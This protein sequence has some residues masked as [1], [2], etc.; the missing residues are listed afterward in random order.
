MLL[1]SLL[2]L[3]LL[4][5]ARAVT[6][7]GQIPFGQTSGLATS[8][9]TAGGANPTPDPSTKLLAA[10]DETILNPPAPPQ[11]Q[12]LN[13]TLN[14][15]SN[16]ASVPNLSIM[17]HGSFYG[18]SIE[19]SVVTQLSKPVFLTLFFECSDTILSGK[20]CVSSIE[21]LHDYCVHFITGRTF[22][23]HSSI[24]WVKYRSELAA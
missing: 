1:S 20:E 3:G 5:T 16:N 12:S 7:Y 10:Y 15:A 24:C 11:D 2:G 23:Y 17:Q 9:N 19:T 14:L 4:S 18:F 13:F 21:V 22:K 6:V 8:T